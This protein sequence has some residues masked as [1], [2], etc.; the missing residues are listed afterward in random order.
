MRTLTRTTCSDCG[1]GNSASASACAYCGAFFEQ[2]A[3]RVSGFDLPRPEV[4]VRPGSSRTEAKAALVFLAIGAFLAPAF[5]FTPILQYM[6]WFLGSLCH[7]MGHVVVAWLAG[8]PSYPAISLAGHAMARYSEQQTAL[9]LL[10][11]GGVA[12]LAWT[13]REDKR[14]LIAFGSFALI[15]PAFAFTG[16]RDF[17][18]LMGGH[19][20]ELALAAVFFQRAIDGGFTESPL[21]RGANATVAW[22]LM[23]RNVWLT[24]GLLWSSEVQSWYARSGSFGLT[25]DYIRVARDICGVDLSVVAGFMLLVSLLPLPLAWFLR[26][27]R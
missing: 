10:M 3:A 23:G 20:G 4:V 16:M 27:R 1:A 14:M 9:A 21:E 7:E 8:C 5:T 26:A 2:V 25:N 13:K 22:F 12:W 17:F 15:Y 18:F 6:G 24:G 11:W 19:I